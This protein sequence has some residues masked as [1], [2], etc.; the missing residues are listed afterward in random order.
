MAIQNQSTKRTD[1]RQEAAAWLPPG[2]RGTNRCR[3]CP[4]QFGLAR[5]NRCYEHG[6]SHSQCGLWLPRQA[7][8]CAWR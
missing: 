3:L 8:S 1:C 2:R 5:P 6:P 4:G 7:H